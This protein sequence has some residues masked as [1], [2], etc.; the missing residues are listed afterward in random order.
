M[1]QET[2][3]TP[4]AETTPSGKLKCGQGMLLGHPGPHRDPTTGTM[5]NHPAI[6]YGVRTPK[7][8]G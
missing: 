6:P 7:R 3:K 5:W 2:K 4:C 8:G 1:K